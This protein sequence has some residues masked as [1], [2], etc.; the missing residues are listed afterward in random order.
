MCACG[1]VVLMTYP[2]SLSPPFSPCRE[3]MVQAEAQVPK[4]ILAG[5][6]SK[7]SAVA[8]T[9]V[10]EDRGLPGPVGPVGPKGVRCPTC[11][12]VCTFVF[13][14]VCVSPC[15]SCDV[16]LSSEIPGV[17]LSGM[18]LYGLCGSVDDSYDK[19]PLSEPLNCL[20]SSRPPPAAQP[21]QHA[22]M[23][24]HAPGGCVRLQSGTCSY[25]SCQPSPRRG[26]ALPV[27]ME[28]GQDGG[29]HVESRQ[30][31]VGGLDATGKAFV[32]VNGSRSP[33]AWSPAIWRK[34]GFQGT[35]GREDH[36]DQMENQ[37]I[38]EPPVQA[39]FSDLFPNI[40]CPQTLIQK[41][42]AELPPCLPCLLCH[43]TACDHNVSLV[44]LVPSSSSRSILGPVAAAACNRRS[45][46]S[47]APVSSESIQHSECLLV[48]LGFLDSKGRSGTEETRASR[49][50]RGYQ[51]SKG[52][53]DHRGSWER[54]ALLEHLDLQAPRVSLVTWDRRE[55]TA[56]KDPR[57]S[58]GSEVY[59][60][61]EECLARRET[62]PDRTTRPNRTGDDRP[63]TAQDRVQ[64]ISPS[65]RG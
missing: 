6:C 58:W 35:L 28:E 62:R 5:R 21:L 1:T 7:S 18:L 54:E 17:R 26:L 36:L 45:D 50:G 34:L 56:L 32:G 57:E 3:S 44:S 10:V 40:L 16:L 55:R 13:L 53:Q 51:G 38:W 46:Y 52:N 41:Y 42:K 59:R 39:E 47:S 4:V 65:T 24:R 22:A 43:M 11:C 15:T 30:P 25:L 63:F 33:P 8:G 19:S 48:K 60:G 12:G 9:V 29:V 61:H 37:A 64:S 23:S 49:G 31:H 14:C 20:T 2:P 27:N